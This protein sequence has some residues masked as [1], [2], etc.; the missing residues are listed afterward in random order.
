[1]SDITW[2]GVVFVVLTV[3]GVVSSV[4][5]IGK[6]RNPI[7]HLEATVGLVLNSLLLWGLFTIGVTN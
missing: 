1:M 2:F 4:M 6:P 3:I 7:T 5:K